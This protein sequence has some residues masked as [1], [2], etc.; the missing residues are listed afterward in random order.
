M[1]KQDRIKSRANL[2]PFGLAADLENNK[3]CTVDNGEFIEIT[4]PSASDDVK[5]I[6]VPTSTS[7]LESIIGTSQTSSVKYYDDVSIIIKNL[8]YNTVENDIRMILRYL[9]VSQGCKVNV[10]LDEQG[11][12]KGFCFIRVKTNEE[13]TDIV[14]R[15]D[16]Y[17]FNNMVL[18]ADVLK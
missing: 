8:P 17:R 14:S 4:L 6:N 16:K 2:K 15:L 7:K 13:A 1:R 10:P 5:E 11:D 9:G 3:Y 12:C 18:S